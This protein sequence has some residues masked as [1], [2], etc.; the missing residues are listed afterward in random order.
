M[1][2]RLMLAAAVIAT[3]T[4]ATAQ[5]D[6]GAPPQ[7][8]RSVQVKPGEPCPPSTKDEVIVCAPQDQEQYRIPKALRAEP[9]TTVQSTSH[10]VRMERVMQD[11]RR[12][13]P[14]SCSP[15]GSNGQ[16]GCAQAAAEA[17]SAEMRAKANGQ[18]V[19]PND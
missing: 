13:L 16:T 5:D 14:G 18:P 2:I 3:P 11:N 9:K 12:V 7:R 17:W 10:A 1:M 4:L 15:I 8:I 19:D 6:A